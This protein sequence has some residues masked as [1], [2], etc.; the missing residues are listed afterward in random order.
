MLNSTGKGFQTTNMQIG[1]IFCDIDDGSLWKYIGGPPILETSWVIV[2]GSVKSQLERIGWST[3]QAGA[4]W[5]NLTDATYYGWDGEN[6]VPIAFGVGQDL[7]N[8]RARFALQDDFATGTQA[9]GSIGSLG[10]SSSGNL[11]VQP[12]EVGRPG[13]V[14]LD[15]TAVSGTL[16]RINFTLSASFNCNVPHE[17]TWVVRLNT[18]DAN[19][20]A[21]VG[22]GN[23]VTANPPNN[24]AYFEKLDPDTNWFAVTRNLT[25]QTRTNT[26]V[27]ITT[28]F[29][30]C[31]YV[32]DGTTYTFFIN[33]VMVA[34]HTTF[35]PA[36]LLSPYLYLI[37]SAAASKTMDVDYFEI[38]A[39]TSR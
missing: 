8:E 4:V 25:S 23:G 19:V 11:I 17:I 14:R 26:G 32:F 29:V 33:D 38:M 1:H 18:V 30:T 5:F 34:Q 21:R 3:P 7:Y 24:G 27:P 39:E 6:L 16:E 13:I 31:R 36:G 20:T 2:S 9:T 12:G 10:W 35:F 15:T 37:N 22:A 28:N